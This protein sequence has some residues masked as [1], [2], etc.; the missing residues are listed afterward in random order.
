LCHEDE[1]YAIFSENLHMDDDAMMMD[2]DADADAVEMQ[3]G[4]TRIAGLL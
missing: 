3:R 1:N 2:A 4:L